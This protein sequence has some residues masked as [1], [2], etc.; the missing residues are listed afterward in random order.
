MKSV[1]DTLMSHQHEYNI[2]TLETGFNRGFGRVTSFSRG[3]PHRVVLVAY[4][5]LLTGLGLRE[6]AYMDYQEVLKDVEK[7][8][9]P[10]PG[11]TMRVNWQGRR[12]GRHPGHQPVR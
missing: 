6:P 9:I 10:P 1:E 2:R 11:T 3:S 4:D 8:L 5:N 12:P 7:R